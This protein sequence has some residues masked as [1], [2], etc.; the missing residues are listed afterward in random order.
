MLR[1]LDAGF[2]F[3]EIMVIVAVIGVIFAVAFP[4]CIKSGA[5]VRKI[6]C[7]ANLKRIDGAIDEWMLEKRMPAGTNIADYEKD[8]YG[9]YAI[10]GKSKCPSAGEYA[11]GI[12]GASPQV[13]CS[14]EAE[15]HKLP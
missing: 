6:V 10:G 12:I 15:G 9:D 5:T 14:K 2:T 13:T 7:I 3:V 4:N 1:K 11:L 8:I